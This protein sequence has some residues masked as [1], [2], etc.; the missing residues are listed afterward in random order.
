[1]IDTGLDLAHPALASGAAS[2]KVV[3]QTFRLAG[4]PAAA[5]AHGTA[6]ATLLIGDSHK[7]MAGLVP[8]VTLFAADAFYSD[9]EQSVTDTMNLIKALDWM[10]ANKVRIVNMSFA[11][12]HDD[13]LAAAI[14][15]YQ[16]EGM[17]F[18]AA[19]GNEGADAPPAFPA[20]YPGVIAVTA[21]GTD[22]KPYQRANHGPYIKLAAPGVHIW[23]AGANGKGGY[24]SGTSFAAPYV[25]AVAAT[26]L[27]SAGPDARSEDLLKSIPVKTL[28][29]QDQS[30]IFGKGLAL[31]PANCGGERTAEGLPWSGG[32]GFGALG[33]VLGFAASETGSSQ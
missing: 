10:H 5:R 1:M 8:D 3:T 31:A 25:T 23:T 2:D 27:R 22:L 21:V 28:S 20:A 26:L 19:A 24:E 32:T 29:D 9:G 4:K 12:P 33:D 7:G 30:P 17:I 11:G 16:R 6:V 13:I 18:V 15:R 14:G